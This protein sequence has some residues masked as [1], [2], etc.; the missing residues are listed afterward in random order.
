M[1]NFKQAT[2]QAYFQFFHKKVEHKLIQKIFALIFF[3]CLNIIGL[4]PFSFA[5]TG[6]P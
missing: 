5:L 4:V 6:H 1:A 2:S 3:F